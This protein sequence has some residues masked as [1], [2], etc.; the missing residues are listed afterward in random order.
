MNGRYLINLIESYC[1]KNGNGINKVYEKLGTYYQDSYG[2]NI[3]MEMEE[4]GQHDI[5]HYLE[6]KGQGF[7]DRYVALFNQYKNEL[8]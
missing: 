7:I 8:K 2:T 4:K 3:V 5:V 1:N 6:N